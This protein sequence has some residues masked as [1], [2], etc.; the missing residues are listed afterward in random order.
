MQPNFKTWLKHFYTTLPA[1]YKSR[2]IA[3]ASLSFA[4]AILMLVG[5]WDSHHDFKQSTFSKWERAFEESQQTNEYFQQRN[6]ASSAEQFSCLNQKYDLVSLKQEVNQLEMSYDSGKPIEG[7]W[8]GINLSTLPTPQAQLLLDHGQFISVG[9]KDFSH[10]RDVLCVINDIYQ[11][12]Q[13]DQ[14]SEKSYLSYYWY[15]KTGSF[16]SLVDQHFSYPELI[17]LWKL[18]HSM[19]EGFFFLPSFKVV[20]KSIIEDGSKC[21]ELKS[22]GELLIQANCLNTVSEEKNQLIQYA[23]IFLNVIDENKLV[24]KESI[25]SSSHWL[26]ISEWKK[27]EHLTSDFTY[28]YKWQHSNKDELFIS[29]FSKFSPLDQLVSSLAHFRYNPEGVFTLD[30]NFHSF[31]AK[32]FFENNHFDGKGL[33]EKYLKFANKTWDELESGYWVDCLNNHYDVDFIAKNKDR[34][35]FQKLNSELYTCMENKIPSFVAKVMGH[36]KAKEYEGC[37]FL[38]NDKYKTYSA[39]FHENLTKSIN[40]R[41]FKTHFDLEKWG[42]EVLIGYKIKNSVAQELDPTAIYVSCTTR[43]DLD[44][45]YTN[46]LQF[47][48]ESL[49]AKYGKIH[50]DFVSQLKHEITDRFH[51][52][53]IMVQAESKIKR[54]LFPY[55]SQLRVA[56][57]NTWNECVK[58]GTSG[59]GSISSYTPYDGSEYYVHPDLIN[60]INNK[61]HKIV[62]KILNTPVVVQYDK[63]R[64]ISFELKSTE[65]HYAH[66]HLLRRTTQYFNEF[67]ARESEKEQK[68]M[69]EFFSSN[70]ENMIYKIVGDEYFLKNIYSK[71]QVKERCLEIVAKYYPENTHFHNKSILEGHFGNN[72][73]QEV[74]KNGKVQ[75]AVASTIENEWSTLKQSMLKEFKAGY[76]K[77]I[78]D[79]YDRYPTKL[80]ID[81][82][83]NSNLRQKCLETEHQ[84]ISENLIGNFRNSKQAE[85]FLYKETELRS[86]I[87]NIKQDII[88]KMKSTESL[89]R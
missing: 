41:V 54:F 60:C 16:L 6:P 51:F 5:V 48:V 44:Q 1:H 34:S 24:Q 59:I 52:K 72:I 43:K 68:S 89:I 74:L 86:D 27:H 67:T 9:E 53:K 35:Q 2:L 25:S 88:Q 32:I 15:L 29:D 17:N 81:L 20:R 26:A 10:C 4:S 38:N 73:C 30:Q 22:S 13:I 87:L 36:I 37:D 49:V 45:C 28:S 71:V 83:K 42:V 23:T 14:S 11:T 64:D 79:C 19:P 78:D 7:Q 39:Q 57:Q 66:Q 47:H 56:S 62:G 8:R 46:R 12:Q 21:S 3:F 70:S 85:Y 50:P 40:K 82:V 69:R 33:Q 18:S 65:K 77:A 55:Y 61:I 75:R 31:L 80:S 76:Q 58:K 84:E 63:K